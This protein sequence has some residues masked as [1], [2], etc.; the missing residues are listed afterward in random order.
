MSPFQNPNSLGCRCYFLE[1]LA[2]PS[3]EEHEDFKQWAG[4]F[5][6]EEFDGENV[7]SEMRML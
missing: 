3:H 5:D 6:P 2:D 4:S 1:A 7:R